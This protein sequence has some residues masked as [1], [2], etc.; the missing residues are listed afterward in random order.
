MKRLALFSVVLVVSALVA[1]GCKPLVKDVR[2]KCT[3]PLPLSG[4]PLSVHAPGPA[5][6]L[7]ATSLD[8]KGQK[9]AAV[10]T[11]ASSNP[12]VATIDS[13]GHVVALKSGSAKLLARAGSAQ[14]TLAVV[15]SIPAKVE[16]CGPSQGLVGRCGAPVTPLVL[17][18]GGPSVAAALFVHDE[19]GAVVDPYENPMQPLVTFLAADARVLRVS[20]RGALTPLA[21]GQTTVLARVG[22]L[23]AA[24]PVTVKLPEFDKLKVDAGVAK[25]PLKLRVGQ[26]RALRAE[27]QIKGKP[28]AGVPIS[29]SSATPATLRVGPDGTA[30]ALKR[31]RGVAVASAAGK[32]VKLS[33]TIR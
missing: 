10:V 19:A 6:E 27:A 15:V 16:L 9:L 23:S 4:G 26:S 12:Q 18:A 20:E 29:W 31:G 25:G 2:L 3:P 21:S 30:K 28:V 13:K 17:R 32:A 22:T 7:S 1:S 24:L 14:S 5:A 11:F 33:V 8:A